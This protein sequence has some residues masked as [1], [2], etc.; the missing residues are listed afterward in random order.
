MVLNRRGS[1]AWARLVL[2]LVVLLALPGCRGT[3]RAA[4]PTVGVIVHDFRIDPSRSTIAAGTVAFDVYDR[5]PST[6][7]FVIV[8]TSLP[9]DQLP[10]GTDGLTVDEESPLLED[11]GEISDLNV[12]DS[13]Q[14]LVHLSPGRYV[15]FCNLEGHYLGGMHALIQVGR[16]GSGTGGS[17][18]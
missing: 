13:G 8:R 7:E 5:G 4:G 10:L 9:P 14:L 6:H 15:L 1:A 11:V 16:I 17:S 3:R 12:G 18:T 2:A